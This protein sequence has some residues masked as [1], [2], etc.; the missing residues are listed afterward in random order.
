M[1]DCADVLDG[2]GEEGDVGG[3]KMVAGSRRTE[4]FIDLAPT[5]AKG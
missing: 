2:Y 1:L 3:V 5:G 4:A